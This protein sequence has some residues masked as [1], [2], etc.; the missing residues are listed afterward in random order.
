M[1]SPIRPQPLRALATAARVL[2]PCALATVG[3]CGGDAR[4]PAEP[5]PARL[6]ALRVRVDGRLLPLAATADTLLEGS[7]GGVAVTGVTSAGRDTVVTGVTLSTSDP[8]VLTLSD[9]VADS[10][11]GRY[12]V[13]AARGAGQVV[14]AADVGSVHGELRVT[15]LR[16]T[17]GH[18]LV[19]T[20]A[21]APLSRIVPDSVVVRSTRQYGSAVLART[22]SGQAGGRLLGRTVAWTTS[23]TTVA[24]VSADGLLEARREG[25]VVLRA[26][27]EGVA[28]SLRVVVRPP[29][30]ARIA[31]VA[32]PDSV[33]VRRSDSLRVVLFDSSGAPTALRARLVVESVPTSFSQLPGSVTLSDGPPGSTA[34]VVTGATPGTTELIASG[35]GLTARRTLA[36]VALPQGRP[37]AYPATIAAVVGTTQL[38]AARG[39][40][41]DGFG[42]GVF[43]RPEFTSAD[44]AVASVSESGVVTAR[45][46]GRPPSACRPATRV[47]TCPSRS[48]PRATSRSR[49]ARRAPCRSRRR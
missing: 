16:A 12:A 36:V 11:S 5:P 13:A 19:R 47:P 2:V 30:A 4:G 17:V 40:D 42:L 44:P 48:Y 8:A 18:V 32:A 37:G 9:L 28:D 33:R 6:T 23:D 21:G 24:G 39:L 27:A 1:R 3:A 25:T 31:F 29:P 34:T 49:C 38:L 41:I 10:P 22:A 14:L 7:E 20:A 43:V 46:S 35:D 26:T 45:A 15:V